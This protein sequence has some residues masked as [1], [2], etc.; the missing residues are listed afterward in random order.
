[1]KSIDAQLFYFQSVLTL[2]ISGESKENFTNVA[3]QNLNI[4]GIRH[5]LGYKVTP[6]RRYVISRHRIE[7]FT[8]IL[9]SKKWRT[10]VLFVGPLIP[11]SKLLV[12]S[13]LGFKGRSDPSLAC[14]LVC[15]QWIS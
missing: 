10:S 13:A 14:F 12:M 4:A 15:V 5:V 1:M 6:I 3:V 7:G 11:C 2:C 8:S 9:F